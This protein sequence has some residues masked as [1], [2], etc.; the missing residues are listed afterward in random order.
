MKNLF[1]AAAGI[2]AS[3]VVSPLLAQTGVSESAESAAIAEVARL[4]DAQI[5]A[6]IRLWVNEWDIPFLD[7]RASL[8]PVRPEG[9]IWHDEVH[10]TISDVEV[11]PMPTVG[12]RYGKFL[13][14]MTYFVPTSYEGK[15]GLQGAV[16][17][18]EIDV[19][20]GYFVLPSVLLSI[21]YKAG[22]IERISDLI[23]HT[24]Q[25]IAAVLVGVS[26]SAPLTDRLSLYGNLAYGIARQETD[27]PDARGDDRYDARY[28]IG[29]VGMSFRLFDGIPAGFVKSASA[30]LGYR[31]QSYT[32]EDIGLGTYSGLGDATPVSTSKRDLR[33]STNGFV[34]ALVASF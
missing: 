32:T 26:A 16:E 12:V 29:E 31:V 18:S 8:S 2:L 6:G 1:R 5:F 10:T 9:I 14:S 27:A 33:S 24:E 13:G 21:G 7:R 28:T 20:L 4:G 19:N 11:V 15:G 23:S 22:K 3:I 30:S 34:L 25:E 17:R